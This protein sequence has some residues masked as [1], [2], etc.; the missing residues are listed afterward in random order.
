MRTG[1]SGA[2]KHLLQLNGAAELQLR[3]HNGT[4]D[5]RHTPDLST[6]T[7][8]PRSRW[9]FISNINGPSPDSLLVLIIWFLR[10]ESI[11]K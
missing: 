8:E 4:L 9:A 6:C 11:F 1:R 5:R 3:G 7:A 10:L 2:V